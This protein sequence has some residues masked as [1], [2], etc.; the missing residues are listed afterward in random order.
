MFIAD[1]GKSFLPALYRKAG[2]VVLQFTLLKP[3]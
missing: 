1:I 2:S 3:L